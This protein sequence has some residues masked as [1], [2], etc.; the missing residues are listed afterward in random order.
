MILNSVGAKN[1][2]GS[3]VLLRYGG[4]DYYYSQVPKMAA[5]Q[6]PS[7]GNHTRPQLTNEV[8]FSISQGFE[9]NYAIGYFDRMSNKQ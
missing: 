3:C 9:I 1:L 4:P 7:H 2:Q 8:L 5:C 6:A